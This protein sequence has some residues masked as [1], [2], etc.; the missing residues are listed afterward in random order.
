L[1][2]FLILYLVEKQLPDGTKL[3]VPV[4]DLRIPKVGLEHTISIDV[5]QKVEGFSTA[6][7]RFKLLSEVFLFRKLSPSV[8]FELFM[9][10]EE[11]T[12]EPGDVIIHS[13]EESG[14]HSDFSQVI[15][16]LT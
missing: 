4:T 7:N 5:G 13:G 6:V 14:I 15:K 3:T 1:Y 2:S 10:C 11:E 8:V 9:Q 16:V 12:V